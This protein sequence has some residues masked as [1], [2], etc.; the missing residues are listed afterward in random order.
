[1]A[2]YKNTLAVITNIIIVC[3]CSA[4]L[5]F[6]LT[7][8]QK[9]SLPVLIQNLS[10]NFFLFSNENLTVV[11]K[12]NYINVYV[13]IYF[14]LV[15]AI[16]LAVFVKKIWGRVNNKT[17]FLSV[18]HTVFLIAI[19]V[20]LFTASLETINHIKFFS[21]EFKFFSRKTLSEKNTVIFGLP[22]KFAM[23]CRELS[24]GKSRGNLITDLD[25]DKDPGLTLHRRLSYHLYPI[26]IRIPTEQATDCYIAFQKKDFIKAIPKDFNK[27]YVF[28]Q[29]N[30]LAVKTEL[31]N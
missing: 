8:Y 1:M 28:D 2:P 11:L 25:I 31:E 7:V 9:I 26:N 12:I 21:S 20:F 15:A 16:I 19:I 30:A 5:L 6:W 17:A 18:H 27:L 22:Y 23:F 24:P 4:S 29:F 13:Y 10:N 3:I 14:F